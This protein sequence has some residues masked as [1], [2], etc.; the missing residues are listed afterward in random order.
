MFGFINRG[1][2][3]IFRNIKKSS[4]ATRL[5]EIKQTKLVIFS[6]PQCNFC[7]YIPRGL[8]AKYEF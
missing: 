5:R 1:D 6:E 2:Q 7:C 4:L 8:V 3:L